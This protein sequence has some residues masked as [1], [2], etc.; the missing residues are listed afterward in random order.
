MLITM[1]GDVERVLRHT[2]LHTYVPI[3]LQLNELA[4]GNNKSQH[5]HYQSSIALLPEETKDHLDIL[6]ILPQI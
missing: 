1:S 3:I 4:L 2:E 5:K 6:H